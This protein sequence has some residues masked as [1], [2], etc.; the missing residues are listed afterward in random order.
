MTATARTTAETALDRVPAHRAT[1]G[2]VIVAC[3]VA[4]SIAGVL[5][6]LFRQTRVPD[7]IHVVVSNTSDATVEIASRHAGRRDVVTARGRQVTEVFVHDIG[8]KPEAGALDYGCTLVEGYDYLLGID[9]DTVVGER[10]TENLESEA[11]SDTQTLSMF[12]KLIRH[13]GGC[14]I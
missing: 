8:Q 12:F 1:I 5:D 3:D 6:S 11:M 2:C 7:V 9:G 13:G 10:A 4:E 14:D